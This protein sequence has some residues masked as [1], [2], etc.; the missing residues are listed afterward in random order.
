M[1]EKP[2]DQL[3][4]AAFHEAGHVVVARFLGLQVGEIESVWAATTQAA[5][6]TSAAQ[7]RYLSSIKS[8]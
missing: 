6:P 4:G 5:E 7:I 1:K 2:S 3:R 8:H